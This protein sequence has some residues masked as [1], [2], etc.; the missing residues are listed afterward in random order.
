MNP[1]RFAPGYPLLI[2][3]MILKHHQPP[4]LPKRVTGVAKAK[5][6][7]RKRRNIQKFNNR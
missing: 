3:E 7:A 2:P 1:S 6:A 4:P 5:R